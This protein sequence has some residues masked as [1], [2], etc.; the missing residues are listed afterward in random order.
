MKDGTFLATADAVVDPLEPNPRANT[1]LYRRSPEGLRVLAVGA[2]ADCARHEASAHAERI[3]LPGIVIV[4]AFVNAHAHL[5]L[6]HVG[7]QPF[8]PETQTFTQWLASIRSTRTLDPADIRGS[9][10]LGIERSLAGGVI[11]VGDISGADHNLTLE[12]LRESELR[13]VCFAELFGLAGR[14][15]ASIARM[16][17]LIALAPHADRGVRLGLQ[18]HAPYSAGPELL[19]AASE[20]GLPVSTH[21]AE[22]LE[23]RELLKRGTGDFHTFLESLGLWTSDIAQGFGGATPIERTLSAIDGRALLAAHV[24]DCRESEIEALAAANV[25][26]VYCPRAHES[27]GHPSTIGPHRYREMLDRGI[28]VCLGT[29]SIVSLPPTSAHRITPFDDARLLLRRDGL[30][31]VTALQLITTNGAHALGMPIDLFRLHDS[32]HEITGLLAL[33]A[34]GSGASALARAFAGSGGMT[35]LA[36]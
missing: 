30:N 11:A 4:P 15:A 18:P 7:S 19:R 8:D 31:P 1:V 3:D 21:L 2:R 26:V 35:W 17:E 25:S 14:Q 13:G 20:T 34:D 6:T 9:V 10:A 27:F 23:E 24:N 22:T 32:P 16:R 33:D 5:D 12:L 28:T 29:D 36:R